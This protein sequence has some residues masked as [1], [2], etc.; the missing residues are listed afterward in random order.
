MVDYLSLIISTYVLNQ[1]IGHRLLS[2]ALNFAITMSFK[3][4]DEM[5]LR[6]Y[7]ESL[8]DD[9]IRLF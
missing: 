3:A 6:P 7:F 1:S 9:D 8:M 2:D 5:H 4:R